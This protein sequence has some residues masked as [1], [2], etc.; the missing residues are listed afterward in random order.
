MNPLRL[1]LIAIM[2][3]PPVLA[4]FGQEPVDSVTRCV[5]KPAVAIS[6]N[7]LYD[8]AITPDIGVEVSL[9]PKISVAVEGIYAWW[10]RGK[11]HRYW[12]IRGAWLDASWWFGQS[13][14]PLLTGHHAGIYASIHDFDFEFGHKGWQS[15]GPVKGAGLTYG[16]SFCLNRRL[17]LDLYMRA[18]YA[19]G[20]LTEYEPRCGT[21]LC[22]R[23]R[24]LHYAGLTCLGVRLVW[25]PGIEKCLTK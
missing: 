4:A 5:R 13:S 24:A 10:S 16:Y 18:G 2:F 14:L 12:R 8:A 9:S 3:L 23:H 21:Y 17:R 6:S 1:S 25:V 11:D 19:W 20:H 7:L 22:I 15:Q